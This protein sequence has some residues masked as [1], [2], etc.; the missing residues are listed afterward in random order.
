MWTTGKKFTPIFKITRPALLMTRL[1]FCVLAV[2]N[3]I[4]YENSLLL[5]NPCFVSSETKQTC[6]FF[7]DI[8]MVETL[9]SFNGFFE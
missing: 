8:Q 6:L 5:Q 3:Q 7:C 4:R 2:V 9:R 1:V